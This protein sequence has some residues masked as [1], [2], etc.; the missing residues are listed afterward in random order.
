M[1]DFAQWGLPDIVS[2][3]LFVKRLKCSLYE[4][5]PMFKHLRLMVK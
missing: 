3:H 1:L 5:F 2:S 4:I